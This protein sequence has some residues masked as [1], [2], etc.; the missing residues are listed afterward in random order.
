VYGLGKGTALKVFQMSEAFRRAA[1]VFHVPPSEVTKDNIVSSGEQALVYLYKGS[2]CQTLDSLRF[3]KFVK[4]V[5]NGTMFVDPKQLPIVFTHI[6]KNLLVS[7]TLFEPISLSHHPVFC[8]FSY[9]P[10]AWC[11]PVNA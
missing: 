5:V 4:K 9:L 3:S 2:Q 6:T 8:S 10:A 7:M 1:S 11:E